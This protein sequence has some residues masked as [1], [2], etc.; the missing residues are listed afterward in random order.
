[1]ELEDKPVATMAGEIIAPTLLASLRHSSK[2]ILKSASLTTLTTART[3]T[4]SQASQSSMR[5]RMTI[6]WSEPPYSRA[7]TGQWGT[8]QR[9]TSYWSTLSR[10]RLESRRW[11]RLLVSH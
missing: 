6:A 5:S 2:G 1:M 11:M 7:S 4:P 8:R 9:W 3:S 10:W